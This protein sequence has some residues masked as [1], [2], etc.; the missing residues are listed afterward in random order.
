MPPYPAFLFVTCQVGAEAAVKG[1]IALRWPSFRF[2]YS[3][4]GFLTFKLPEGH[5]LAD[6]FDLESVFARAYGFSLG[7][8]GGE[9]EETIA[10]AAWKLAVAA[11][12]H[13]AAAIEKLHVWPRDI[14]PSGEHGFSPGLSLAALSARAALLAAAP[15]QSKIALGDTTAIALPGQLVL[16][17]V[18]VQA[19]EWWIGYHRARPGPS[20]LPGGLDDLALPETAVSRAWLKMEEALRWSRFKP[21]AGE[22]CVEIGCAPG[23]SCQSLL[24]RGLIVT[25]VDPADVHA[26]V[27]AHPNFTHV[28]MRGADIRRREFRQTDWLMAD[29]NVAPTYTLDA[30]EAIVTHDAVGI[31]GLLLTLKLPDWRLAAELPEYLARVRSWGYPHAIARQLQHCRQ[32]VCVAAWRDRPKRAGG[33]S[34]HRRGRVRGRH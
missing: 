17:C 33:K 31:R 32:E 24:A 30:V 19:N 7:K 25:G 5:A 34:S 1:E 20:C 23:G 14:R 21:A 16:D 27:L 29:M 9:T 22:R 8:V 26:D 10:E 12:P 28:R 4:P 18:L 15:A 3:R 6:D 2:A 13:G 11:V